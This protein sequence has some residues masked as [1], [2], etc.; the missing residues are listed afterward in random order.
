MSRREH[1]STALA[2]GQGIIP[3]SQLLFEVWESGMT[4]TDLFEKAQ[5]QGSLPFDSERRL[6]NIVI[7][8]FGSRFLQD[9]SQD[10]ALQLKR[11]FAESTDSPLI[12]QLILLF[13]LRQHGIFFDF[14]SEEYWPAVKAGQS[15]LRLADVGRLIDRGIISGKLAKPW[16]DSVRKRVSSYTIGIATDFGFLRRSTGTEREILPWSPHDHLILFLVYDLHFLGASDDEVASAEEWRA[17]GFDREDVTI[18]LNRLQSQDH[19]LVQDTGHLCRIDW[20]YSTRQELN[21]AILR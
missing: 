13:A 2:Q 10:Q 20:K 3:E 15:H 14:V 6:R 7:E 8:A 9:G 21:H 18:Y 19:L 5:S 4:P 11:L 17:F 16:S 12:T 1:Y